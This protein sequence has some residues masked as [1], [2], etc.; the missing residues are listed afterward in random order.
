M[1]SANWSLAVVSLM[2][3][4]IFSW[5]GGGEGKLASKTSVPHREVSD[6]RLEGAGYAVDAL[7]TSV[8]HVLFRMTSFQFE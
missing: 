4:L 1:T 2:N 6:W 8:A 3:D 7:M 5:G